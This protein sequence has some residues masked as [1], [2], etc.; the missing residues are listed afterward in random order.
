MQ[1]RIA[2][3]CSALPAPAPPCH[4]RYSARFSGEGTSRQCRG[5]ISCS[6][7]TRAGAVADGAAV[8]GVCHRRSLRGAA[9][10]R[11]VSDRG[12]VAQRD[13]GCGLLRPAAAPGGAVAGQS[14]VRALVVGE[15]AEQARL[16]RA[17]AARLAHRGAVA[18]GERV[19]M[20]APFSPVPCLVGRYRVGGSRPR[21]SP[22]PPGQ[23]CQCS[24]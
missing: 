13:H 6:R 15:A 22:A 9:L 5:H 12:A 17:G 19:G 7:G 21:Y 24:Q 3:W 23:L 4:A 18:G 8:R 11:R 10:G 1:A 16:E 2:C 14:P 20:V